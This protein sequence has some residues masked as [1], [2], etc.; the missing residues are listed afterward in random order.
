MIITVG[1]LFTEGKK[2]ISVKKKLLQSLSRTLYLLQHF[3]SKCTQIKSKITRVTWFYVGV[4]FQQKFFTFFV[5]FPSRSNG[6]NVCIK[7]VVD[8]TVL[9]FCVVASFF[10][11][12]RFQKEN[13][14]NI[15][16]K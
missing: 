1:L 11:T 15:K 2:I 10:F 7:I 8:F 5:V 14:H 16:V 4:L 12:S 6:G 3:D 13:L 9:T